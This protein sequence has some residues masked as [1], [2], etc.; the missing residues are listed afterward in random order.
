MSNEATP[1]NPSVR[2]ARGRRFPLRAEPGVP[3]LAVMDA[4][5]GVERP[6]RRPDGSVVKLSIL[7]AT[8]DEGSTIG[9]AVQSVL[10]T[11]Y[12]CEFELLV[13]DDGSMDTT[14]HTLSQIDDPRLRVLRHEANLGKGAALLTAAAVAT[15]THIVPFD[16]DLEY[17]PGD[18]AKLLEPVIAGRCDVVY[19]ARLFGVN[20]V[21]QSYRY[22]LGNRA[23]T[24]AAN[25]LFDSYLSDLHT[26]LK[27]MPLALF[28]E[29]DLRERGF[30]LD[31]EVTARLLQMGIRPFEVPVSY[32]SRAHSHG[33]KINWLDGVQCLA[34]LAR[35][36]FTRGIAAQ[37]RRPVRRDLPESTPEVVPE[38]APEA[39]AEVG[40]E[41]LQALGQEMD[42]RFTDGAVASRRGAAG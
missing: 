18:I 3:Q 39:V 13:V 30:G 9:D 34:I 16:S 2:Y 36:R 38:L 27:L 40:H 6:G 21:Y 10:E 24:T 22:A 23:L 5:S 35:V 19:G 28:R 11:S 37:S 32:H 7:M 33:K 14:A 17:S 4:H 41:P 26:C 29:L 1:I 15:G 8:F 25:M 31:T 12:P 42:R 20:T